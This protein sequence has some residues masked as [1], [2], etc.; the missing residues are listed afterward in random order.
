[1]RVSALRSA[2][3]LA[4]ASS[5]VAGCSATDRDSSPSAAGVADSCPFWSPDGR[6]IA[7]D[8]GAGGAGTIDATGTLAEQRTDVYVASPDGRRLRRLTRTKAQDDVLGWV[9]EPPAVVY[10]SSDGVFAIAVRAD[11]RPERLG[12]LR[13]DDEVM[14]LSP[15]GRKAFVIEGNRSAPGTDLLG[16]Q[17][18]HAYA[19]VDLASG[20]RR[21]LARG[22]GI[23]TGDGAW[24]PDGSR[25]AY[26][27][28]RDV[29]PFTE[30][31]VVERDDVVL[32]LPLVSLMGLSWAPD[33]SALAYGAMVAGGAIDA[34]AQLWLLRRGD[35]ARRQL[36]NRSGSENGDPVWAP[37]G[38][39]IYYESSG[40]FRS[41]SP[42]GTDDEEITGYLPCPAVSPDGGRIAFLR[43]ER[44]GYLTGGYSLVTVMRADGSNALAVATAPQP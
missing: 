29:F 35:L 13:P 22:V 5:C 11:S 8:R 27:R 17:R 30:L 23:G 6:W 7:F 33:G 19:V 44:S 14:T 31:V 15:D 10:R 21:V 2:A 25:L 24:S 26:T 32:R 37:D 36:T 42:T 40:T 20:S 28:D 4:L 1:M 43:T 16:E 41:I 38:K 39:R 9:D 12:S 18:E 34:G 3:A